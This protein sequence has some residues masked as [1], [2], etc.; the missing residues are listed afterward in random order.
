M[1]VEPE[2]NGGGSI[3]SVER[4]LGTAAVEAER[5]VLAYRKTAFQRFPALFAILGL[6]G[7]VAT[8]FGLE[9]VME[10]SMVFA[11]H[12]VATLVAGL[13]ILGFTGALYRR[14]S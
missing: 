6:F 3:A 12:P 1:N 4:M 13:F 10:E 8:V 11:Q 5:T 14:L 9:R 2:A 7:S